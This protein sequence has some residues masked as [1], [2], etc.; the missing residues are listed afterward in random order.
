MNDEDKIMN[1]E[2]KILAEMVIKGYVPVEVLL[3]HFSIS[4]ENF[5]FV[6]HYFIFVI[7]Y[8]LFGIILHPVGVHSI[9]PSIAAC[10]MGLIW[11]APCNVIHL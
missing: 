6:I 7:H 10:K 1:D 11:S 4:V 3:K 8:F 2:D 9:L 5:I